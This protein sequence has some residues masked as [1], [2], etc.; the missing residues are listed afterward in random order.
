MLVGC[1]GFLALGFVTAGLG[2]ALPNLAA[3]T[4]ASLASVGSVVTGLFLGSLG[5]LILAGPLNDRLGQRPLLLVGTLLLALGVLGVT[6]SRQLPLMLLCAVVAGLGHGTL[7]VSTNVLIA[8]V[9]PRRSAAALNLLNV[10]FGLGA[11]AGPLAASL[12]LRAWGTAIPALWIGAGLFAVPFLLMPR[13]PDLPRAV[14]AA[15]RPGRP[16]LALLR[17]P[18]L[19]LLGGLLLLYVGLENG[20]ASWTTEYLRRTTPLDA[21]AAALVTSGF[22]LAL[23]AGRV[24]AAVGGL[25]LSAGA[26]LRLALGG[27]LAGGLL[28]AASTGNLLVSVTAVLLTGFCYGP[29]FPT[30]LAVTT[31]RFRQAPGTAASLVVAFASAGGTL[32]PWLHGV[33]LERVGPQA[34]VALVAAGAIL[35]LALHLVQGPAGRRALAPRPAEG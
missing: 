19:W 6:A 21:A 25:R 4:G 28:L 1:L 29:V 8:E 16:V 33:V 34:S 24:A 20:M 30:T 35:M 32:L 26:I 13:L 14:P 2:P 12:T 10:F 5:A 23:T 3:Q 27:A 31:A 18:V 11:V 7:D 22:W 17:S 9:F 15:N